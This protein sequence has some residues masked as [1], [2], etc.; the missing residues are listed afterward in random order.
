MG[1]ETA[2]RDV[3]VALEKW[4]L[5]PTTIKLV[6]VAEN[7]TFKVSINDSEHFAL[8]FHR[9]G[10]HSLEELES[11]RIWTEALNTDGLDCPI[12][13][14][15]KGD[16]YYEL[17]KIKDEVR[18]TG[19][20]EWVDGET[21]GQLMFNEEIADH[22]ILRWFQQIGYLLGQFHNHAVHW[23][24]PDGFVRHRIDD[25]GLMGEHP[26]WGRFWESA[27]LNS[28]EKWVLHNLKDR[29][30]HLLTEL[31]QDDRNFSLIHAD[32]HPG[33][34]VKHSNG[35]HVIDFDDAGFGWHIYDF[36]VALLSFEDRP[37]F[38]ELREAMF[39][40]YRQV[41]D[42]PDNLVPTLGLFYIVRVLAHIG[43]LSARPELKRKGYLSSQ[44]SYLD[45]H[46]EHNLA[47]YIASIH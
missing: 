44:M 18:L 32:L 25:H 30:F 11:E 42:L 31:P 36:A 9:P 33:N 6:S 5:S 13:I 16:A 21:I 20:T 1:L 3:R 2:E 17:C 14:R 40:G 29:C 46:A 28:N 23:Q 41:R 4:N 27:L 35:L 39:T 38:S 10:Y 12:G 24:I 47:T 26:F 37:N 45:S 15:S 19:L 34:V 8:R 43:W 22:Q 7:I